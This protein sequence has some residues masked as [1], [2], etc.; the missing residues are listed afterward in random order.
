MRQPILPATVILSSSTDGEHSNQYLISDA[1]MINDGITEPQT[2]TNLRQKVEEVIRLA[3]QAL[4]L[5][6]YLM[7]FRMLIGSLPE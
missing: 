4:I 2:E 3:L 6:C 5:C 7:T 1:I